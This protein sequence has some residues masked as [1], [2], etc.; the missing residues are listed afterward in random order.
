MEQTVR[1]I[2]ER[3]F[4]PNLIKKRKGRGGMV[5]DY[6][7]TASVIRRLNEAFE[8]EWNFRILEHGVDTEAK[9]VWV[10]GELTAVGLTK[11]QFGA[12]D[13]YEKSTLGDN[14]K[15]AASDCLKKCATLFG[16]GLH[17]YEDDLP[18]GTVESAETKA[19]SE[20]QKNNDSITE[21][22]KAY[23]MKLVSQFVKGGNTEKV[24]WLKVWLKNNNFS[25]SLD[26][27]SASE[28]IKKLEE[29]IKK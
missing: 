3:E 19:P 7:E 20:Q 14:L 4:E 26:K 18:G 8:S 23:I 12:K 29:Q 27:K 11:Q 25:P 9:A 28:V 5:L 22:Q 16:V 24:D 13:I 10:L 17:L 6:L 15:S 2:L 21:S 1:E